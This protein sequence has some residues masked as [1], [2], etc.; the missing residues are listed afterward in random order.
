MRTGLVD[1]KIIV[2]TSIVMKLLKNNKKNIKY[3]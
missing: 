3:L 2:E 1:V